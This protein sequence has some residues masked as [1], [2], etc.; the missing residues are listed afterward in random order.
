MSQSTPYT[1]FQKNLEDVLS[2][3]GASDEVRKIFSEPQNI[4]KNEL[5]INMDDGSS[6]SFPAFRVQFNNAR[7]PYKGGIRFHEEADENEVKALAA[8]MAI[9]TA[10]V[11]IPFGGAKGGVQCNPKKLSKNEVQSIARAY[12]NAFKDNIGP[13][14]DCPAPDVNTNPDIMAWMR[15]EY[16]KQT[17]TFSP[18]VITGKPLSFGGSLGRGTATAKGGFFILKELAD[19]EAHDA[20]ELKVVV[21]G[22]GN[23]GAHIAHLLH[24][25]GYTV[26]AVSDSQGGIYNPDGIDPVRVQKYKQKTGSVTGEYCEGSVCDIDRMSMD[27][28]KTVTN[29]EL[30]EIDCDILVPA[31]L[32]NVITEE[33]AD[34]I[35]ARYIL[36]LAN[37]PTTPEAD[38]ILEKNGVMVI[39]DV[40]AN[41]GGVTV[42]YFEWVQGRSGEQWTADRVDLELQRL[43]LEGYKSVR[44]TVRRENISYRK[45]AFVVGISR[46]IESM[47][48]RGW[49]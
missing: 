36:E 12:V 17:K 41:A 10:V 37:G 33:N 34:R 1:R 11:N 19:R 31:A 47:K 23:A 40:L 24:S 3:L 25:D 9:K 27:G 30:L 2:I 14:I 18:H 29:E 35:K 5:T 22:F 4:H 28:V 8:L 20:S 45:A 7:G 15:D 44:R 13:D 32:D 21:Q 39:P 26:V 43:I 49:V 6:K 16:E 48:V 46:M 38:V 42:S